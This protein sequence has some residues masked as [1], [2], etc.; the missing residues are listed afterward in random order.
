M[1][2][3]TPNEHAGP[4]PLIHPLPSSIRKNMKRSVRHAGARLRLSVGLGPKKKLLLQ[5]TYPLYETFQNQNRANVLRQ[6]S[7]GEVTQG[8]TECFDRSDRILLG[9]PVWTRE[10][11]GDY[12]KGLSRPN[13]LPE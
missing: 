3:T 13:W 7:E 9:E 4:Q 5:E 2:S 11:F 6:E 8:E 12:V 10:P 1:K